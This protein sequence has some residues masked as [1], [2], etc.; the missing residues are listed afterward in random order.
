MKRKITLGIIAVVLIA[1]GVFLAI[2]QNHY[3]VKALRYQKPK[4]HYY[5]IFANRVVAKGDPQPWQVAANYNTYSL[6]DKQL[7]EL[8]STRSVAF[9]VAQDSMLLFESYWE[10]YGKDSY[11]NSFSMAKSFISLLV[12]CAIDD[13]YIAGLDQPIADFLPEFG[14][15][16]KSK[17]TI[18]HLLTMSS[19]LSWDEAYSSL[20]S[21]TTQA[22]YGK[23]L[24]DL[25]INQTVKN[26]PGRQ[27]DY[28]S[29]DSQLLSIIVAEAT[30]KTVSEYMSEKIWSKIGAEND[31]LWNLD[32]E[33]GIEKAF[34]CFNSNARDFARLGRLILHKGNWDGEQLISRKYLDETLQPTLYLADKELGGIPTERY[35][36]Q[37][38]F[39][40]HRDHHVIFAR[41]IMGQYIF[42][43]PDLN[44]VAV[45]LGHIRHDERIGGHPIDVYQYLDI[46]MDIV[47]NTGN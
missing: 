21:T 8:T 28:L 3:I 32:K 10:D 13:G 34:C 40:K 9:L 14:E 30:G 19:G 5:D 33:D 45:R 42:V 18:R 44:M 24:R 36:H 20:F 29:G 35:G 46:A 27:F 2:P 37:W 43:V 16:Q 17:I 25:V 1:L 7:D 15:G 31:A 39:A 23:F 12:G 41:G 38:W 4:I 26:E 11:S 22:Y 47:E 6:T